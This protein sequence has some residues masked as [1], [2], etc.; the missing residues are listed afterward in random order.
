MKKFRWL[1]IAVVFIGFAV[2]WLSGF[3]NA[4]QSKIII[5][6]EV[7]SPGETIDIGENYFMSAKE[8]PNGYQITVESVDVKTVAEF[9]KEYGK[10]DDYVALVDEYGN[11]RPDY[12]YD[13][14][15]SF[16]NESNV[17]GVIS[18]ANYSLFNKSLLL[19]YDAR[20]LKAIHPELADAGSFKLKTGLK[21]TFHFTFTADESSLLIDRQKVNDRML[22]DDFFLCISWFPARKLVKINAI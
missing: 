22:N 18:F 19:N 11:K 7:Y 10:P 9:L 4:N 3:I 14:E 12:V 15:I 8:N 20:F 2:L 16:T 13:I 1:L 17:D 6:S 5:D 21:K